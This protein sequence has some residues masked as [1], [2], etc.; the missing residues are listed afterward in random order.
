MSSLQLSFSLRVSSGIKTVHLLGSW[1]NYSGQ[2][3]LSKD[4]T[5]SKSG[6]WK[7]TF[8]FNNSSLEAGQRY[9][10][11]YIIDGYHVAHNP[12]VESTTEPTTGRQLNILDVPTGSHKSS[13]S[14][15]KSSS[16]SHKSSS[17]SSHKSSSKSSSSSKHSSSSKDKESHRSSRHRSSLT[18]DIP[19]GR[20]L[21]TSQIKAPK[22][23]SPRGNKHILNADYD[24]DELNELTA[25]FGCTG[26][27]EEDVITNFSTSPVSSTGSSLSYRSD[28][29]S[30][31]SSLSGYSTPSS[32]ITSCTCE[33]YGITRKG[34]RVRIDCGGAR[35]GYDESSDCSSDG[36][37]SEEEYECK[38]VS[39]SS[40]RHGMVVR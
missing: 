21:S 7:G 39:T 8:R 10:Y 20:P 36:S 14:S 15:H 30:P 37:E 11:Y 26:I 38:P 3:P 12:S 1:D 24:N 22:P 34:D 2:L 19:K 4:K 23:M 35:C 9:W 31:S 29:S 33:R 28:S 17:S 18:L 6:S 40:R 27:D 16:S 32:D 5:S 13:S 25:R